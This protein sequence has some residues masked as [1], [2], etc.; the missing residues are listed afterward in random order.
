MSEEKNTKEMMDDFYKKVEGRI[1]DLSDQ[2]KENVIPKTEEKLK[3]NIF[4]TVI[5]SFAVGFIAGIIVI[6]FGNHSAKKR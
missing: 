6:M 3:K 5:V 2:I 1:K 4:M